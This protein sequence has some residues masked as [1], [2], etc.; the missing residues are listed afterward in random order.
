MKILICPLNWG[1]GHA[2]RCVPII[3]QLM[4]EGHELVVVANGFPL[5]F[6]RQEFPTLRFIELPSYSISYSSGKSQI[7]SMFFSIPNI[8]RGIVKE[9]FWL[10]KILKTEH[11]DQ[12]ISDNRFGLWNKQVHS[13]YITHQL[14]VKMPHGLKILEPLVWLIHRSFINRYNECWIP[15][16]NENGGL[17][18][19]LSHNYPLP[20]NAKFIGIQSRFQNMIDTPPDARFEIVA[21]VSGIEPQRTI[22][23]KSLIEKYRNAD[24]RI[25]IISGQ[26]QIDNPETT[27]GNIMLVTHLSDYEMVSVLLGSK[28]I[29]SRSGYSTIMDLYT[30]NCL[31]KAEFIATPGQTEQ[32][33]L[34]M[35]HGRQNK[36]L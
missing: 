8:I 27:N 31:H 13:I 18:G 33:Y 12:V 24:V 32:E 20:A 34:A 36:R 23:E 9:H 19:D 6:L 1:L 21:I 11:Y 26:P 17:S 28:K 15:D 3:Q 4:A 30:L 25:L 35:I 16:K 22:F 10:K 14:M 5:E 7:S 2:T 29:I